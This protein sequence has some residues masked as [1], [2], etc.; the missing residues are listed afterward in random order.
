MKYIVIIGDGMAD[1]PMEEL[2]GLTVLQKSHTPNM[3]WLAVRGERGMARTIPPGMP[4]GSDVA[5][6]SIMGY[7]PEKFYTGRAPLEAV[8]MGISMKAD[9]VAYRCNIVTLDI[10]RGLM[11]DHSSGHI[12]SEEG[13]ELIE[14]VG[15][16]LGRDD[17]KFY[18]GVSYRHLVIWKNGSVK[19]ACT[20][21]HDILEKEFK[22]YLPSGDGSDVLRDLMQRSQPILKSHAVNEKRRAAGK[23]TAD[24]IWLWGQGKRPSVPTYRDKYGI[25]G[26]LISAVDLTK[27]LGICAGLEIIN[28]PGATG[29]IDTNYA[30][31]AQH[32]VD[33]LDTKDF[34]YIHVEAPDEAG[35]SGSLENKI[36]A[37]EDLDAKLIGPVL[38]GV[39]KRYGDFRLLL[40][41]DHAT[42]IKIRTHTDEPVPYVI[43]DSRREKAAAGV[44]YDESIASAGDCV[45]MEKGYTLMDKFIRGAEGQCL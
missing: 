16:E 4:P 37:V 13:K 23:R 29:W 34:V 26:S 7:D 14:A 28:V 22:S 18:P 6:L 12:T 9:D 11:V 32:A 24:S 1:R 33:A 19:P 39:R 31:K 44:S 25:T 15:I 5:N 42:P 21:P 35:H 2:G 8:S 36:K 45:F 20:P 3:D 27:G 30:G 38:E 41:P 43:Y 17:I 40:M 10:A